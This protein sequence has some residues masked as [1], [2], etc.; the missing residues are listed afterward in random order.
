MA[1][2]RMFSPEIV[3]SDA[4]IEMPVSA[5]VLYFHL[6]MRADDDGFVNPNITMRMTGANADDLRILLGK[7][8]L[9]QFENGVVVVKHWRINN[10]IRKDRY[11][12]TNYI[13]Q[14][15]M[16]FVKDNMAYT[17]DK[18]QG[19]PIESVVWKSDAEVRLSLGQPVV[20]AGEVRIGKVR[21]GKDKKESSLSY[22][23]KPPEDVLEVLSEKYFVSKK[24]VKMKAYDLFLYCQQKGKVYKNYKAFLENALRKD[25]V[26]L[27]NKFPLEKRVERKEERE[28]VSAEEQVKIEQRKREIKEG[29]S[30]LIGNKKMV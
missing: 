30:K 18:K 14:K 3:G 10:F 4:F 24:G 7:R 20:N 29:I 25:R 27:Q 19:L 11:K 21:I 15:N 1:S 8:F 2:R 13:E 22:L 16:L 6:G 17:L 9:I 5:Q 12:A 28:V 23:E 26:D